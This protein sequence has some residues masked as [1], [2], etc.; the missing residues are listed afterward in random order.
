MGEA[1]GQEGL[2]QQLEEAIRGRSRMIRS[3]ADQDKKP[4]T[5]QEERR[6]AEP[7]QPPGEL[8]N[9]GEFRLDYRRPAGNIVEF[10]RHALGL[11]KLKTKKRNHG[12]FFTPWLVS[13][14]VTPEQAQYLALLKNRG[15]A[16]GKV[17]A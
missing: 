5:E 6:L 9:E 3:S 4:L 17:R 2:Y 7:T 13:K 14:N 8:F 1:R 10:I 12:E 16:T 11:E 15:V